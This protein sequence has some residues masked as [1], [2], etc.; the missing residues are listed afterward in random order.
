MLFGCIKEKNKKKYYE[1]GEVKE[2]II[3]PFLNDTL[4]YKK[5]MY[6]RSGSILSEGFFKNGEPDS[7]YKSYY[8]DGSVFERNT[9]KNGNIHGI[10]QAFDENGSIVKEYYYLNG[11][12]PVYKEYQYNNRN[13]LKEVKVYLIENQEP[14]Y[15]GGIKYNDESNIISD[16]SFYYT[17]DIP[18]T[19]FLNSK[20]DYSITGYNWDQSDW[21]IDLTLTDPDD[22]FVFGGKNNKVTEISSSSLYLKS[23]LTPI[24]KG[25]QLLIGYLFLRHKDSKTGYQ[26]LLMKELFIK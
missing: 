8:E 10:A 22:A 5:I 13:K 19:L 6:Y 26:Y 7:I 25:R 20:V 15:I 11:I 9:Y 14:K 3:Y 2:E 17:I 12:N 18:D 21:V 16:S 24:K 1:T 4:F 23:S